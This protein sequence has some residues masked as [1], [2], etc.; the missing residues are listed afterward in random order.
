MTGQDSVKFVRKCSLEYSLVMH[1]LRGENLERTYFGRNPC[2]KTHSK[3][4][5]ADKWS[6][7]LSQSQMEELSCLEEIMHGI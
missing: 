4:H 1:C 7:I 5:Y 6:K 3:D 2:S